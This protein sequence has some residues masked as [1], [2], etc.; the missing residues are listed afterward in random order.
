MRSESRNIIILAAMPE[1]IRSF[2][3]NLST[4]NTFIF[5]DLEIHQGIYK[6]DKK[7]KVTLAWSGWGKVSSSRAVARMIALASISDP[8]DLIIFTGVAGGV[9]PCLSQ[10]DLVVSKEVV[11]HDMD[12]RPLF[13]KFVIP[14]LNKDKLICNKLLNS[15]AENLFKEKKNL[16]KLSR[17]GKIKSGLIATGDKFINNKNLME[18][19]KNHF[20][21]LL[22]VEMEGAA[23]A[24]VAEQE[25]IPWLI[26]RVIS[27]TAD[28]SS[29]EL[30]PK[31]ITEYNKLSWILI[32]ILVEN[33]DSAPI[34]LSN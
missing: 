26:L 14:P 34:F 11:Q 13:E 3:K 23:V 32:E 17:F 30:F 5:G 18:Q 15:W 16:G 20:D 27:D 19:I 7:I 33:L 8:I 31:F 2:L 29:K 9:D 10:W 28:E 24:Q 25:K 22:A 12:A 6:N 1:E 4:T 21:D